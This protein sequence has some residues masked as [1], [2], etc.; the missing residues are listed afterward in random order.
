MALLSLSNPLLFNSVSSFG[1]AFPA[2]SASTRTIATAGAAQ[3]ASSLQL[4]AGDVYTPANSASQAVSAP[5]GGSEAGQPTQSVA[6]DSANS[7]VSALLAAAASSQVSGSAG[8]TDPSMASLLKT[9][10]KDGLAVAQWMKAQATLGDFSKAASAAAGDLMT[11]GASLVATF[12]NDLNQLGSVID[13]TT[14]NAT[15]TPGGSST[16]SGLASGALQSSLTLNALSAIGNAIDAQMSGAGQNFTFGF[17]DSSL[18]VGGTS[19]ASAAQLS[20]HISDY[21]LPPSATASTNPYD[22]AVQFDSTTST[23]TVDE[24][25]SATSS[26]GSS[27]AMV[28]AAA[29]SVENF[30]MSTTGETQTATG[31]STLTT[32]SMNGSIA[33]A[34]ALGV[35]AT[36]DG[37]SSSQSVAEVAASSRTESLAMVSTTVQA[38]PSGN[39]DAALMTSWKNALGLNAWNSAA[40]QNGPEEALLAMLDGMQSSSSGPT[41]S[42][43]GNGATLPARRGGIDLYA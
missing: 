34:V 16:A 11:S 21:N 25:A 41:N 43:G 36:S 30:T 18:S 19:S 4:L 26:N 7:Q 9:A 20:L 32:A 24:A 27:V 39:T 31:Q 1:S 23:A 28:A 35:A 42:A 13:Q 37:A 40:N 38:A 6:E 29:A 2:S 8:Q 14:A 33:H 5:G 15:Q 12:S 10:E 3:S 22:F 17:S